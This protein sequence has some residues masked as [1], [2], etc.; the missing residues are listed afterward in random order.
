MAII[1][2]KETNE[3]SNKRKINDCSSS[4]SSPITTT[5]TTK[6]EAN[7]STRTIP[8]PHDNNHE[9]SFSTPDSKINNNT[10]DKDKIFRIFEKI[11]HLID[12]LDAL[13][14]K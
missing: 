5:T 6:I 8:N 3:I 4:S 7:N 13:L 11:S 10:V 12:E 9:D 14:T 1:F 2:N